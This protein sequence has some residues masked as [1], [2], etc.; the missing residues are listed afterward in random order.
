M[1]KFNIEEIRALADK[2]LAN[3][4][5]HRNKLAAHGKRVVTDSYM[6]YTLGAGNADG[7]LNGVLCLGTEKQDGLP[8]E[9]ISFFKDEKRDFVVWVR[10]HQDGMNT[11]DAAS[12]VAF[13]KAQGQIFSEI[14]DVH[15]AGSVRS[16][17][18]SGTASN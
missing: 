8:E 13:G 4:I 6:I 3:A 14:L 18:K 11:A 5:L 10:D 7:H 9:A 16:D 2:N 12:Y 17:P 15:G 1:S